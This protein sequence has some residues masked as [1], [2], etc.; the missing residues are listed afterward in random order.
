[1]K[2]DFSFKSV[3]FRYA[4]ITWSIEKK[5]AVMLGLASVILVSLNFIFYWSFIKQKETSERV[6]QSQQTLQKIQGILSAIKDA[7]TGQRGYLLTGRETYLE[8]YNRAIKTINPQIKELK[9]LLFSDSIQ[10]QQLSIIEPLIQKKI[11]ELK[12]TVDL[13][14][15]QNIKTAKQIVL[16]NQGQEFMVQIRIVIQKMESQESKNLQTW[17]KAKDEKAQ[18]AQI[19]FLVG[20]VLNFVAFYLVSQAIQQ[21]TNERRQAEALFKQLNEELDSKVQARTAELKE[22]N[23]NLLL[24]NRELEQFAY[25]ASHDLQ[26]PLRAVNSY[27]QLLARKYQGNLDAKADKY[28]GYIVEGSTRMQQLI[29][30]LLELSRVGTRC[31]E[32]KLTACETVLSQVLD[33]LKVAIA[34]NDALVTH[35]PLPTVMGDQTQLIQLF[36]NLISNA[37]KFRGKEPP[38]VHV[39]AVQQE[40]EWAFQVCDNGIGMEAEYFERIFMIF[41]RLN[42]RKEYPGT[43]IGLA[44]CKKIVERHGGRIWVESTVGIGT[45]F[46]FTLN[47][48]EY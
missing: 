14:K 15:N 24:S 44:I 39:S 30:D 31:K 25:V 3:S 46:H 11:T 38:R 36:Q 9:S 7:E 23:S 18:K 29:N 16:T 47:R 19:L 21:E 28:I 45:T 37:I 13:N 34:Q 41:Q 27:T 35:D 40:N 32:L 26:E 2:R 48:Y 5:T 43:G 4:T 33:N 20:I 6:N 22:V 17:L 1:M 42:S 10:Q 12:E 8:P